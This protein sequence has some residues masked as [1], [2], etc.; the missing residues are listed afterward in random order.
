MDFI[1]SSLLESFPTTFAAAIK[2]CVSEIASNISSSESNNGA[3]QRT[4]VWAFFE[5]SKDGKLR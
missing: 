3:E 1:Y 4:R 2:E 5:K